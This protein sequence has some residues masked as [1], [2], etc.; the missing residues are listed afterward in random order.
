MNGHFMGFRQLVQKLELITPIISTLQD[1][2]NGHFMGFRQLVQKL[3]RLT[4]IMSTLQDKQNEWSFHGFSSNDSKNWSKLTSAKQ[5]G[6]QL[7]R[8]PAK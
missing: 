8:R 6:C 4:P 7:N 5:W 2:Q 3:D 1:K